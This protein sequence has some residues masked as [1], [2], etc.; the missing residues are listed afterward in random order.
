MRTCKRNDDNDDVTDKFVTQSVN[1]QET[2]NLENLRVD[3]TI[4][5]IINIKIVTP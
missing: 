5:L 3:G 1:R 4:I 2:L